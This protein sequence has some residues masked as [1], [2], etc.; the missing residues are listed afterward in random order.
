MNAVTVLQLDTNF[1]RVPGDVGCSDTYLVPLERLIVAGATVGRIVTHTPSEIQIEPFV[2]ALSTASG[3]VV[4]SSCGFLSYWQR[5]L[6]AR[7]S[8]PF[9]SSSLIALEQLSSIYAPGE[10]LILTFDAQ[11]LT[12]AHLGA[13]ADYARG[14]VGLPVDMHLRRVISEN[15]PQI[16]MDLVHAE[17]TT[18]VADQVRPQHR[19]ILLECTNLPPYK[20]AISASIDLPVTDILTLIEKVRP[21]TVKKRFLGELW[22]LSE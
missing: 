20:A 7:T 15:Q 9:I 4:V 10:V 11:N 22:T 1:P 18:F 12:A 8:K 3:D 19:H 6:A 17:L 2:Q 14:I 16:D 21:G 5:H 13:H